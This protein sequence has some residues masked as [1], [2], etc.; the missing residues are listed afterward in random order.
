ML[1]TIENQTLNNESKTKSNAEIL[2]ETYYEYHGRYDDGD[3]PADAIDRMELRGV[4][5]A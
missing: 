4:I 2:A 3:S 5:V 1:Q